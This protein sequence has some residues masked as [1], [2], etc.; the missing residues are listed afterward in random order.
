MSTQLI[1]FPLSAEE[2]KKFG[3]N[4]AYLL[5]K[6]GENPE[7]YS[8]DLVLSKL[9]NIPVGDYPVIATDTTVID[10]K[11]NVIEKPEHK[12]AAGALI[13]SMLG[14]R[15]K[16]VTAIGLIANNSNNQ[17]IVIREGVE[18][19]LKTKRLSGNEIEEYIEGNLDELLQISGGIDFA[20]TGQ[21]FIDESEPIIVTGIDFGKKVL[22]ES[23]LGKKEVKLTKSAIGAIT[24]YFI[25]APKHPINAILSLGQK[26]HQISN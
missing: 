17:K 2:E 13:E 16:T 1:L 7:L 18:V 25:G 10:Q 20:G 21:I 14:S 4:Y 9:T 3:E 23:T 8:F 5:Q 26:T 11:G 6:R 19:S 12:A 15:I 24:T 22:G